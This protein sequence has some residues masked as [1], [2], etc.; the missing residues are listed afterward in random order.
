MKTEGQAD[1]ETQKWKERQMEQF[2]WVCVPLSHYLD[3]IAW[4]LAY[5]YFALMQQKFDPLKGNIEHL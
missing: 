4:D 2:M 1:T 5:K 3:P